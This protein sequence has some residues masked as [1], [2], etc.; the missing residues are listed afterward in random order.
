MNDNCGAL[1]GHIQFRAEGHVPVTF[2]LHNRRIAMSS[3]TSAS[4]T[5]SLSR[6]IIAESALE[7]LQHAT[8]RGPRGSPPAAQVRVAP[9]AEDP[10]EGLPGSLALTHRRCGKPTCHCASGAGHPLWSLT[11]MVKGKKHVE[12]IPEE[13]LAQVRR[14]VAEGR[15]LSAHQSEWMVPGGGSFLTVL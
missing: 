1:A 6:K 13:W 7:N 5:S 11:F 3:H 10:P 12:R 4:S 2:P 8:Q 14:R 15:A 9:S